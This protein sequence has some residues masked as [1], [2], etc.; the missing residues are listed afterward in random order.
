MTQQI[1]S[2][3]IDEQGHSQSSEPAKQPTG[4]GLKRPRA[5]YFHEEPEEIAYGPDLKEYFAQW[6]LSSRAQIALCRT[7]A[8][9]LA[10]EER[11]KNE[12]V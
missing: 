1:S 3:E 10:Q 7:Y 4:F 6:S 11:I 8:N 9:Y 12:L 2:A 5:Q